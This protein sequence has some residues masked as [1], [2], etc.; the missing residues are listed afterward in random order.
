MELEGGSVIGIL[1]GSG[2][3]ESNGDYED[4][5]EALQGIMRGGGI[6]EGE[7]EKWEG[8]EVGYGRS[9]VGYRGERE[10]RVEGGV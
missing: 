1:K 8:G 9:V 3:W 7:Y 5:Y 6:G 2:E 10:F 4:E